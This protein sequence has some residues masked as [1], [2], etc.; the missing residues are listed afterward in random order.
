MERIQIVLVD[1]GMQFSPWHGLAAHRPFGGFMRA[2]KEVY[3][4][5]KKFRAD[6]NGR[7]IEE[8][9]ERVLFQD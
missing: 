4:A 5:A 8:P 6:K 1:E 9:R 7:L 3:E 2:R